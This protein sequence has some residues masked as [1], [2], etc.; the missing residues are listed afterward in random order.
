VTI[1]SGK[2]AWGLNPFGISQECGNR[3]TQNP[4]LVRNQSEPSDLGW[5]IRQPLDLSG[6]I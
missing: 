6:D 5:K 3:N 1:R 4:E 2:C